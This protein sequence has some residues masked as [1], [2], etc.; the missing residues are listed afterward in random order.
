MSGAFA[1]L[2]RYLGKSGDQL[3]S[4]QWDANDSRGG[5]EDFFRLAGKL[6]RG[7]FADGEAGFDALFAG[8]AV[9]VARIHRHKAHAA[10]RSAQIVTAHENRCSYHAISGEHSRCRCALGRGHA[11]KIQL[12]AWL[13][14][15]THC[16]KAKTRRSVIERESRRCEGFVRHCHYPFINGSGIEITVIYR[17][18]KYFRGPRRCRRAARYFSA[19]WATRTSGN[20]GPKRLR[21]NYL[22]PDAYLPAL[23]AGA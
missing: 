23:S 13:D 12:A 1:E 11:C 15:C 17:N 8:G 2:F 14:A 21:E 3:F 16:A 18:E 5:W 20:S 19:G 10:T 7:S 9:R 22:D 4:G 6:L